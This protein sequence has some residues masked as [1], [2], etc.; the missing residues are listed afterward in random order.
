MGDAF[1]ARST[2]EVGGERY[3]IFRLEPL[4]AQHDIERLPYTLKILL[5]NVLRTA[6]PESVE[7][8]AQELPR[9]LDAA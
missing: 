2:L 8:V 6:T 4:Q 1:G 5:E 7:A 3:E 9:A